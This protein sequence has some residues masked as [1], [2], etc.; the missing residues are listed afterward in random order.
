MM[1]LLGTQFE[2]DPLTSGGVSHR[3]YAVFPRQRDESYTSLD[4]RDEAS[5]TGVVGVLAKNLYA[6]GHE[7][8]ED[9]TALLH[10][11]RHQVTTAP[12]LGSGGIDRALTETATGKRIANEIVIL[13]A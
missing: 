9:P 2:L 4:G 12:K 1:G 13:E 8:G 3:N 5:T 7:S 10:G 6:A 11:R